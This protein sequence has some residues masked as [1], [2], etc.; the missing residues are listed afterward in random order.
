MNFHLKLYSKLPATAISCYNQSIM[1]EIYWPEYIEMPVKLKLA[2]LHIH[3]TGSDGKLTPREAV[4][5]AIDGG[6]AA[7]AITDHDT[8]EPALEAMAYAGNRLTVIPGVERTDS[9]LRHH[10]A[11]FPDGFT[12]NPA[13]LKKWERLAWMVQD[14]HELGG[15]VYASHPHSMA[16]PS[17]G[18]RAIFFLIKH[19]NPLVYI[20]GFEVF[21][22][23]VADN[24]FGR[25]NEKTLDFYRRYRP[26]L[27][28]AIGGTDSHRKKLGRVV[29]IF[30]ANMSIKE[31]LESGTTGVA[32][33]GETDTPPLCELIPQTLSSWYHAFK[34]H[35]S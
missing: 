15:K 11:L 10:L 7:I 30:P 2:D 25:S 4:D 9:L 16:T 1:Q 21:N 33:S 26:Y 8:I 19:S 24:P 5:R 29:T 23:A 31:A 27:G 14:T 32:F 22:G 18:R 20:D 3:T 6:L 13:S 35:R 12:D 28:A 17:L 34:L